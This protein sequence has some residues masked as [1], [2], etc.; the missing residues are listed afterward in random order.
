MPFSSTGEQRTLNSGSIG[1]LSA[2][3]MLIAQALRTLTMR[4]TDL[5]AEAAANVARAYGTAGTTVCG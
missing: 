1:Y 5:A 3:A 4:L 2:Q